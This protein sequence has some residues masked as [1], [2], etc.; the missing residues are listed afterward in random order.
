MKRVLTIAGSDS[1]VGGR[2]AF[3][4]ATAIGFEA[5]VR[6]VG[7]VSALAGVHIVSCPVAGVLARVQR[8][9]AIPV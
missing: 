3:R 4:F 6:S 2:A 8:A 5:G 9:V 7:G 1:G